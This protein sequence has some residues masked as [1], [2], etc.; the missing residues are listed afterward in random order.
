MAGLGRNGSSLPTDD[1]DPLGSCE[2]KGEEGEAE[3][4][5][6]QAQ[7]PAAQDQRGQDRQAG[8]GGQGGG[9]LQDGPDHQHDEAFAREEKA[10]QRKFLQN[11]ILRF[12]H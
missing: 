7:L 8:G 2:E 9:P 10:G 1:G 3:Q 6:Q 4:A 5:G 12:N 11:K